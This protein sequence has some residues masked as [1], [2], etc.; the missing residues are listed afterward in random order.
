MTAAHVAAQNVQF[1]R[2]NDRHADER[3]AAPIG[4]YCAST[5]DQSL[6]QTVIRFLARHG[7][8]RRLGAPVARASLAFG[9]GQ[10]IRFWAFR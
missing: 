1:G 8:E 2:I 7:A 3:V 10:I 6:L 9:M 4:G 5:P